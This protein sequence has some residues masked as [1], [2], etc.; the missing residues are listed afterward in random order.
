MTINRIDF[1][2]TWNGRHLAHAFTGI[3]QIEAVVEEARGYRCPAM[4]TLEDLM[5]D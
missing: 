2:V 5:A 1:L 4:R 3:S